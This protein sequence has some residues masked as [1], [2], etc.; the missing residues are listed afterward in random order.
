MCIFAPGRN[1]FFPMRRRM[2]QVRRLMWEAML[3]CAAGQG[4]VSGAEAN[5]MKR[6]YV[7]NG[8]R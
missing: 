4:E 5:E 6:K 3:S 7:K 2:E 8:K 1:L